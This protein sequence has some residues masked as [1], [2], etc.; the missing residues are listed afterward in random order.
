MPK[1]GNSKFPYTK[2]GEAAAKKMSKMTGEPMEMTASHRK[3]MAKM[4]KGGKKK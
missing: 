1:V 3:M 2:K 4:S